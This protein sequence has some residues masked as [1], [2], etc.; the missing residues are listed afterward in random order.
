MFSRPGDGNTEML[1][2]EDADRKYKAASSP[3]PYILSGGRTVPDFQK[4]L[5]G[6]RV[7]N[8]PGQRVL[9]GTSLTNES[10]GIPRFPNMEMRG[11]REL[12]SPG[13]SSV[14]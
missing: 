12:T 9:V 5:P 10:S 13:G 6:W 14:E 8:V 4:V 7:Q 11:E 1:L 3:R 2:L